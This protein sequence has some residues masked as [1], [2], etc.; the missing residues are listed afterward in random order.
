MRKLK[1]YIETST[2][3]FALS[4]QNPAYKE[5][6]LKLFKAIRSGTHEA[7]TS[8]VVLREI[9]RAS[10]HKARRLRS[11]MNDLNL[12]VLPINEDI[13]GLAEEYVKAKLIPLNY[14]DD[15]LHIAIASY[16]G[17]DA[18]VTWNFEHMIKWQT[19]KGV[20]SVNVLK[21]FHPIEIISPME[22]T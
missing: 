22:V 19:K 9:N 18:I 15:A 21:G 6:T 20:V 2:V 12:E 10:A 14:I 1:L 16:Y 13:E 7:Y 4:D 5:A 8:E 17:M 11:V 3:N